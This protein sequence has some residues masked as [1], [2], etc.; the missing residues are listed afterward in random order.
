MINAG[1][2]VSEPG[3]M[4]LSGIII[5]ALMFLSTFKSSKFVIYFLKKIIFFL[6]LIPLA[7]EFRYFLEFYYLN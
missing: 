6:F 4:S 1:E 2:C 7:E 5:A 3:I